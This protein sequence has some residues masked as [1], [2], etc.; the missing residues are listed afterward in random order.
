MQA[1]DRAAALASLETALRLG[2][3]SIENRRACFE[4]NMESGN[5]ARAVELLRGLPARELPFALVDRALG[6]LA[7]ENQWD[8]FRELLASVDRA[9]RSDVEQSRLLTRRAPLAVRD[10]N[11]RAASTA[12][13]EALELDPANAD[14]L[15]ALGQIHRAD[16]DYGRAELVLRRASDYDAVREDALVA[17]A[18]VA[19]DREDFDRALMH[20]R[21]VVD[22]NPAR[23]DLKRNID[24]LQN[25]QL[26]RTQR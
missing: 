7:N 5:V 2:D 12:L 15:L 11:R 23:A 25:L 17:R 24:L 9:S 22:G 10:G 16:R 3:E 8:R 21:D 26:L 13:Q 6:W 19:I 18:E 1:D 4:L 14:A 20:L